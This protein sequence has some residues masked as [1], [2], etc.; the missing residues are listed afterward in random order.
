[1]LHVNHVTM[2]QREAEDLFNARISQQDYTDGFMAWLTNYMTQAC[3]PEYERVQAVD[4]NGEL[5]WDV[6]G[7][8]LSAFDDDGHPVNALNEDG[9]PI[10]RVDP[11][12]GRPVMKPLVPDM[13][14]LEQHELTIA[15]YIQ[16][17]YAEIG[18]QEGQVR[19]AKHFR[20]KARGAVKLEILADHNEKGIKPPAEHIFDAMI[21]QSPTVEQAE[22]ELARAEGQLQIAKGTAKAIEVKASLIPGLQGLRRVSFGGQ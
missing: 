13:D 7:S 15:T 14:N 5:L 3:Q 22:M 12:T 19:M 11:D 6:D 20:D 21:A 9:Y 4:E 2:T 17:A 1:M 8:P 18:L 10:L 16:S